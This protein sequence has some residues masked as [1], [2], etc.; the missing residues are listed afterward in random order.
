MSKRIVTS[1]YV[2]DGVLH[3]RHRKAFDDACAA[4]FKGDVR[5]TIEKETRSLAQN[6]L[7]RAWDQILGDAIGLTPDDAHEMMKSRINMVRRMWT[8]KR[9][10]ELHEESFPGPTHTMSKDACSEFMA[11]Y[12]C[13]AATIGVWLPATEEEWLQYE[14]S[15]GRHQ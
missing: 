4:A 13:E 2:Q 11:N 1:G 10:G 6:S 12:L 8:D 9:T 5:I 7:I 14:A 3:L 15:L